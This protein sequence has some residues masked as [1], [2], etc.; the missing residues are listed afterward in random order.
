MSWTAGTSV[1]IPSYKMWPLLKLT[2]LAVL[3]DCAALGEAWEVLVIDND[4]GQDTTA[5]LLALARSDKNLRVILR[6]G[7]RGRN[8]QPGAARNL[9]IEAARY[10]TLVFLDADCVPAA[11]TLRAYREA[12]RHDLRTVFLGHRVFI[13]ASGVDAA[14]VARCRDVLE[15]APRVPSASNYGTVV[16]RR[17]PELL[18]LSSADMPFDCL[19]G[20][21]FAL[22][23]RCLADERFAKSFDGHWGYEDIELGH[24]LHLAGRRFRYLPDAYVYHQEH[25]FDEFARAAGRR[26]NFA[27]A[28]ALIPGFEDHRKGKPRVCGLPISAPL[29]AARQQHT[30]TAT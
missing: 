29:A 5:R 8:F 18:A 4:S 30:Q 1:V 12:A 10:D 23:R 14:L 24:R 3:H 16:D 13:E 25:A 11:G 26:R 15:R 7:L 9:G 27:I 17:M 28:A 2:L 22:H 6:K 21:N 20:C 19:F